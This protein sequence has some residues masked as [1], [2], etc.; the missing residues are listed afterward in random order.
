MT[1]RRR[2]IG[3]EV[4]AEGVHFRVWAPACR[5]VSVVIGAS[6]HALE[7]ESDGHF[8]RLAPDARA[9]TRYRFRLDG[10][11]E[12]FPDPAAAADR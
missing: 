11:K 6:A 1:I 7:R 5:S 3:A 2:A 8:S 10:A 9:G 4:T 12:T